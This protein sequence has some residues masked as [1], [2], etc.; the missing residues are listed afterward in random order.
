MKINKIELS[1]IH[2]GDI[3]QSLRDVDDNFLGK[4]TI[5][6]VWD[7]KDG[8]GTINGDENAVLLIIDRHDK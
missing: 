8:D 1:K 2:G 3:K 4:A 7:D 6:D 5:T